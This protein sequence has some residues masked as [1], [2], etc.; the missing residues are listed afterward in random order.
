M[1]VD[2][3]VVTLGDVELRIGLTTPP[4]FSA[5]S[6]A[7]FTLLVIELVSDLTTLG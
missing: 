5:S 4:N 1:V 2:K 3:S 6:G 7:N